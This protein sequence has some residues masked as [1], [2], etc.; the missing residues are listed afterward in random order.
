MFLYDVIVK[1]M[2]LPPDAMYIL[3]EWLMCMNPPFLP[4][5]WYLFE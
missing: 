2:Q 3:S 4:L 5:E 1:C